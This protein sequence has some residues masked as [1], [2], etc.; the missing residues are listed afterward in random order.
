[1]NDIRERLQETAAAIAVRLPPHTGFILLACDFG[2]GEGRRT[3]YVANM[4]RDDALNLMAEFIEKAKGSNWA[5]HLD[6]NPPAPG[7][8]TA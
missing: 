1:M 4:R 8:P 2:E 7:E 3:E 5:K 6:E